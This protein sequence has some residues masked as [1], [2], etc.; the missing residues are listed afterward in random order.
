MPSF[1][2]ENK[3]LLE[4]LKACF[5]DLRDGEPSDSEMAALKQRQDAFYKKI[6]M[7]FETVVVYETGPRVTATAYRPLVFCLDER[8]PDWEGAFMVSVEI[9]YDGKG[10]GSKPAVEH[11]VLD[12]EYARNLQRAIFADGWGPLAPVMM[13]ARDVE[14]PAE[15]RPHS[16]PKPGWP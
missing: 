9:G 13:F 10:A 5:F 7:D 1:R 11:E 12:E 16:L 15:C 6:G 14:V 4:E 8:H 3:A 2:V